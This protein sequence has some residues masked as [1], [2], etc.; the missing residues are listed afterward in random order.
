M[1]NSNLIELDKLHCA[2]GANDELYLVEKDGV[3][4]WDRG[5]VT[6][7]L[8]GRKKEISTQSNFAGAKVSLL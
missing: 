8:M 2:F 7:V 3:K 1:E 5:D 4:C 6:S